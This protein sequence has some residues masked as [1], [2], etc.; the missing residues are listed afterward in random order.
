MFTL[1]QVARRL[2]QPQRG[3][4]VTEALQLGRQTVDAEQ[5]SWH[6]YRVAS[7]VPT[8][9]RQQVAT[10]ALAAIRTLPLGL[11]KARLLALVTHHF[12][13]PQREQLLAEAVNLAR[14]LRDDRA[15]PA[16]RLLGRFMSNI[17]RRV[18]PPVL[19]DALVA[20]ASLAST[21]TLDEIEV[22][23]EPLQQLVGVAL[24]YL[25]RR[26]LT[27]M[28]T[29]SHRLPNDY[30]ISAPLGAIALLMPEP[31]RGHVSAIR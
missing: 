23:L 3:E 22:H 24:R 20:G 9:Q 29:A 27:E 30:E 16:S 5:R 14:D 28:I 18:P 31:L 7:L 6:L 12:S 4:V 15:R 2:P 26:L 13:S 17:L 21:A 25:P 10:E 8:Q 1:L 11:D 19:T